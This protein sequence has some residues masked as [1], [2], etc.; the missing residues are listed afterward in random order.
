MT[1]GNAVLTLPRYMCELGH[2]AF[3]REHP[4]IRNVTFATYHIK[5]KHVLKAFSA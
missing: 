5:G 1:V 2:Y 3:M 4:G